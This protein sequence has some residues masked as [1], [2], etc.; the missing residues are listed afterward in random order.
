MRHATSLSAGTAAALII[1]VGAATPALAQGRL[2]VDTSVSGGVAS[3]PFLA[4]GDTPVTGSAT[5]QVSPNY[6]Y[7]LGLTR[8][9]LSGTATVT[10]YLDRYPSSDSFSVNGS[11]VHQLSSRSALR[12]RLGYVNSIVGAFNEVGLLAPG[13]VVPGQ[14]PISPVATPIDAA[15]GLLSP[16]TPVN[17]GV[18]SDLLID[19]SLGGIGRRRQTFT[20]GGGIS[21]GL[22][23]RDRVDLD[24]SVAA[25]R[26]GG[27]TLNDFNYVTQSI[28]YRRAI[29][30]G[31]DLTAGVLAGKTDYLRQR[32]N[33]AITLQPNV[34]AS[35]LLATGVSLNLAVGV[36]IVRSE[37]ILPRATRTTTS[38]S[39][40]GNLCK[41]DARTNACLSVSRAALPSSI[42]GIRMQTA[43]S[44]FATMRVGERSSVSISALYSRSGEP[45]IDPSL[46]GLTSTCT[47]VYS[48]RGDYSRR[49]SPR[50]SAFVSAGATRA[51][52]N[53]GLSRGASYDLRTGVRARF[54]AIR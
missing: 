36:S 18:S 38:F 30:P 45:L 54:G 52:E 8:F 37:M 6:Q 32:Q 24:L 16:V 3:N 14:D 46:I 34:G 35:Y 23:P 15:S 43:A 26:S 9:S 53:I 5:V 4:S 19:P 33:D 11:G 28:G 50:L 41:Q 48:T 20:G 40:Q 17:L 29:R 12:A 27:V 7:D 51:D 22:G 49:L 25:V 31:F 42:G 10:E 1:V 13:I 44:V 2:T 47:D 21:T 39:A